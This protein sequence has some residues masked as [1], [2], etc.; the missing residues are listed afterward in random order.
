MTISLWQRTPTHE[1]EQCDV[2]IIGAGITGLSAA[3]ELESRGIRCI[4]LEADYAG[5]KASGRNAGYLIRG[6]A[7]NYALASRNL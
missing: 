6:A 3:I 2:A 1:T 4:V 5:S 7:E